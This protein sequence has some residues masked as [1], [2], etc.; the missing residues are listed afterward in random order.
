MP[1]GNNAQINNLNGSI[2]R[3]HEA[4]TQ[5][6]RRA[7][8][9]AWREINLFL[10]QECG[11][12]STD[13]LSRRTAPINDKVKVPVVDEDEPEARSSLREGHLDELIARLDPA[14]A[15]VHGGIGGKGTSGVKEIAG[16]MGYLGKSTRTLLK[17]P[18][19]DFIH[20]LIPPD[21]H[22]VP[23][24]VSII[25]SAALYTNGS[26]AAAL[27]QILRAQATTARVER[28]PGWHRSEQDSQEPILWL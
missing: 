3:F 15:R 21:V 26:S 6:D 5:G 7:E 13:A 10:E 20:A 17:G 1:Q 19:A 28:V 23:R 4:V 24:S 9:E 18:G 14:C 11:T 22:T 8:E 25:S 16:A 2:A 27:G 12:P